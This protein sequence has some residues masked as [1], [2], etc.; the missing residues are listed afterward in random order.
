MTFEGVPPTACWLHQG[1]R[2]GFEVVHFSPSPNGLLLEGN[3]VGVQDVGGT[4]TVRYRLQVDRAWHT[5]AAW[6]ASR[7]SSGTVE[8]SIEADGLGNWMVDGEDAQQLKGCLDLDLESSAMTNALPVHRLG[9]PRGAQATAPAAYVGLRDA[10]VERLEQL[11]A[12]VE[13]NE[14][15]R[16]RYDYEA[17]AF[18]F[19]CTL[20]Y[21]EAGL[22]IE[23]PGIAVRAG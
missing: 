5:R 17:P 3:S 23:Y 16:Q 14:V 8:R 21:D 13:D 1:L 11:Y 22:I 4:W 10:Q 19:R 2:S 18:E 7:T 6:V 9:L 12:R 15:G 20:L